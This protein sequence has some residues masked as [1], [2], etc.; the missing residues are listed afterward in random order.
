MRDESP[1]FA[2]RAHPG[3]KLQ[4]MKTTAFAVLIGLR[5]AIVRRAADMLVV[6]FGD[7]RAHPSGE[8]TIGDHALHVQCPWRFDGPLGAVTGRDDLW[9][10]AG[11]GERPQNWSYEDGLSLQDERLSHFFTRDERTHSWLNESD[12]FRVTGARQSERGEVRLD[13]SDGYALLVFPASHKHEAW[14]L[15]APRSDADHLVFPT[16][17]EDEVPL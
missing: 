12:R 4:D 6:H 3:Y 1:D 8:G 13:L 14:R 5:L 10:Y 16:P 15:F 17:A 9:E 7:I 2:L 11:P